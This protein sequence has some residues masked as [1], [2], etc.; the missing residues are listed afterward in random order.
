MRN[1]KQTK[2]TYVEFAKQTI[3]RKKDYSTII[4]G[5]KKRCNA[6]KR[7]MLFNEGMNFIEHCLWS[8]TFISTKVNNQKQPSR[9][10]LRKRCSGNTQ[11]IYWRTPM[12]KYDFNNVGKQLYQNRTSACVVSCKFVAYFQNTFL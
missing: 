12:L 4:C 1:C 8:S 3:F 5:R 6:L 11:Q 9:V 10:V 7:K 2:V